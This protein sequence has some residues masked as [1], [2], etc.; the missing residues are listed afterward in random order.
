M[1]EGIIVD[2]TDPR[3]TACGISSLTVSGTDLVCSY[4]SGAPSTTIPIPQGIGDDDKVVGLSYVAPDLIVTMA[5][6][7]TFSVD[8]TPPSSF[9][10][11][12]DSAIVNAAGILTL[13]MNDGTDV[14]V[15]ISGA[16]ASQSRIIGGQFNHTTNELELIRDDGSTISVDVTGII[17]PFV[18]AGGVTFD[19]TIN[20]KIGD[21][22]SVG[23]KLY[24]ALVASIGLDPLTNPTAWSLASGTAEKG[25]VIWDATTSY[26]TGD[27]VSSGGFA[28][29]SLTNNA[30][31]TPSSSPTDWSIISTP[32]R[33][34]VVWSATNSYE[35]GD[36]V[37]EGGVPYLALTTSSGLPPSTSP[38]N[39]KELVGAS[40]RG[41][42]A[43]NHGTAYVIDDVAAENGEIYIAIADNTG[44]NPQLVTSSWKKLDTTKNG[45][46]DS[47]LAYE[48]GDI[49]SYNGHIYIAP[50]GGVPAGVV[51]PN[52]P[53]VLKTRA[54]KTG[55]S[56]SSIESYDTGDIV[57]HNM[58][59]YMA[60]NAN[61]GTFNTN[62][63]K[64]II[65]DE[66]AGRNW[67]NSAEYK[68][69]D[70][71]AV[72]NKAY[73]A[74]ADN[75][76]S[77]PLN[78]NDW[79]E[80]LSTRYNVGV[81]TPN[82]S[83]EYPTITPGTTTAG[84][85]WYV[86]GIDPVNG[87]TV[88]AGD[89]AGYTVFNNDKYVY[90]GEDSIGGTGSIWLWEPF[91]RVSGEKGGVTFSTARDYISGDIVEDGLEIYMAK[92]T[93][94][95]SSTRPN[96]DPANWKLLDTSKI[97][98]SKYDTSINYEEGDIV[99]VGDNIY[100]APAGGVP[101]GT[102]PPASPWVLMTDHERGGLLYSTSSVYS[103]GDIVSDGD[104]IFISITGNSTTPSLNP[105]DWLELNTSDII[106]AEYDSST[107]YIENDL[108]VYSGKIY[109]APAGGVPAGTT[110][111]AP[112]WILSNPSEK[113]G[114]VWSN[115]VGYLIGDVVSDGGDVFVAITNNTSK[116]PS[117]NPADWKSN[118]TATFTEAGGVKW[119][120]G[121]VYK[122][123]DVVTQSDDVYVALT[124]NTG[125]VPSTSPSHWKEVVSASSYTEY[126]GVLWDGSIA[127][128]VGD[129]VS[130]NGTAY[131]AIAA[132]T[133]SVPSSN[134]ADWKVVTYPERGGVVWSAGETYA[135][136]DI[137]SEN[138]V[139]FLSLTSN[140]GKLP[141]ANISDW[142]ELVAANE[143]GGI[144]WSTSYSYLIGDVVSYN[145]ELY[146]AILNS[147]NN[148]PQLTPS[149]WKK[150]DTTKNGL[151][152]SSLAYEQGDI[153]TVGD[154]VYVAP[155]GGVPAGNPPPA[156][157]WMLATPN[158]RGGIEY[159]TSIEYKI[160]DVSV[161]NDTAY[162]ALVA[163]TG[164]F[165]TTEWKK[166]VDDEFAGRI[167][168]NS[169]EYLTGDIV[170]VNNKAYIAFADNFNSNPLNGIDWQEILSTRYN[171]G[172]FTPVSGSA[173][174]PSI[175]PGSTVAGGVWYVDGV[176]PVN[177]VLITTGDFAGY[178]VFNNDKYVYQ[179]EDSV[180][181]TGSIWLWEAFPR[182]EGEKG[183]VTFS[184]A[185][186]YVTG[187]VVTDGPDIYMALNTILAS[188]T[189]PNTDPANWKLLDTNKVAQGKY[190]NSIPYEEGDIVTIGDDIYIAPAGG[191]SAGIVPPASPWVLGNPSERGGLIWNNATAY[192]IGDTTSEAGKLYVAKTNHTN[193]LPSANPTDWEK[194]TT[195]FVERGGISWNNTTNY[196]V[197]DVVS[198]N[199]YTYTATTNNVGER[200]LTTPASW[201]KDSK[202]ERGGIAWL[203]TETYLVG[204]VVS[205]LGDIYIALTSNTNVAP[206][207]NPTDW[208]KSSASSGAE[209]GGVIWSA[210][211]TYAIGDIVSDS[212]K[213]YIATAVNTN[214]R[215]STTPA[216]WDEA[217]TAERAGTAWS[218]ITTYVIGDLVTQSG[219]N[220]V[221]LTAS[222]NSSP[223]TNPADWKPLSK[224]ERGGL[225]WDNTVDYKVNDIVGHGAGL[226]Y[227]ALT[228]N[229]GKT[230]N[231]N[232]TDWKEI[233]E[234]GE[235]GGLIWNNG[236]AYKVGDVA[237]ESDLPYVARTNNT[238][239]APSANP[240]DW[241]LS[242]DGKFVKKTGDTMSSAL[243]LDNG[244]DN[245][246]EVIFVDS[247]NN[248]RTSID[249]DGETL[250][251]F[252]VYR[253][254]TP[255][256]HFTI[257]ADTGVAA[258]SNGL[259]TYDN[260]PIM[261]GVSS[262]TGNL[263]GVDAVAIGD[264]DSGLVG[265]NGGLKVFIN[266]SSVLNFTISNMHTSV[267]KPIGIGTIP[268]ASLIGS[269]ALAIGD[270]D[271]GLLWVSDGKYKT[272]C[273]N[274]SVVTYSN[275]SVEL[276]KYTKAYYGLEVGR[277]GGGDSIIQFYD[278]NS[279]TGRSFGWDDSKNAFVLELFNGTQGKVVLH[280]DSTIDGGT[281]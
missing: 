254:S 74:F 102:I 190:D 160:G 51:P 263:S 68:V 232:P 35:V 50:A 153:V 256:V 58:T 76:N 146:V 229:V 237:T 184:T 200:P 23:D 55:M 127:Y 31:S 96:T 120:T 92:T 276:H 30:G 251:V 79:Q 185:R 13:R 201:N 121:T 130:E 43:W 83:Q 230:P 34:G 116:V 152:D 66:S 238:N 252:Q 78:G 14:N 267:N 253:G 174:Y 245:T 178:T 164:G 246:P 269:N 19:S 72:R 244:T 80:I 29:I 65:E 202:D 220:Y 88:T 75:I 112:P 135:I 143:R 117:S 47:T 87:Y 186:D 93:I 139:P 98:N 61:S 9:D 147:I 132:S 33:G 281:Y 191:V 159:S 258:F 163:N 243:R 21:V 207:T 274:V 198:D 10:K 241:K 105:G 57:S 262:V 233:S 16:S 248:T 260:K 128:K 5:S 180:G 179:G 18:E 242:G 273:N 222:T 144:L 211:Y 114:I 71:V 187:D 275:T 26:T 101:A 196:I 48:E 209:Y 109:I 183:G 175:T 40:E 148:N 235:R 228:N 239:K 37:S 181:G 170:S 131:I 94:L 261:V 279:N 122:V 271:T 166:I 32:E 156:T 20:Y 214:E 7:T 41:G 250:R 54:V 199:G 210:T 42:I 95:A 12:L 171:V 17:D 39:W 90:Q 226:V 227:V 138:G 172:T 173:E 82:S 151:Y 60:K 158:E 257:P 27:I 265:S 36:I 264:T 52:S 277:N 103:V 208:K 24:I 255:T 272:V 49:I 234:D 129:M 11:F 218:N 25:G 217:S 113:G 219:Q 169:I 110:P 106:N 6:G 206:S 86:D 231:S 123:G 77:D 137:V 69:G 155:A 259:R 225:I 216:S 63:W 168:D 45:L 1:Q 268:G 100:T 280:E 195:V 22:V 3:A 115:S 167:W 62:D 161:Y 213:V 221:A 2:L 126:G 38:A 104:K 205:S 142:K 247:V 140:T 136:G 266:D 270:A 85:V 99:T 188:G 157:P 212:G 8:T 134:P 192:K 236:T 177:G 150:L 73:I 141:S 204:D 162:V 189:R 53:W 44:D 149:S 154:D 97:S 125:Q 182:V 89:F 194:V 278:D 28:Y 67:N 56:F 70:I 165:V 197:G 176:D 240:A 59:G 108:V 118:A 64:K 81:F 124:N 215:P 111:P 223:S 203:S 84:G 119:E 224:D 193:K 249:M 91:P 4:C 145:D 107:S 15:D 46:Y 133:G